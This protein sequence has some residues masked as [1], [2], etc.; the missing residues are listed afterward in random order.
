MSYG[1]P[2]V[3][4]V[5]TEPKHFEAV[6]VPSLK[7]VAHCVEVLKSIDKLVIYVVPT[8]SIPIERLTVDQIMASPYSRKIVLDK[9]ILFNGLPQLPAMLDPAPKNQNNAEQ[10]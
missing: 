6:I 2:A 3:F 9:A 1:R 4:S 7:G 8:N 5:K 10:I